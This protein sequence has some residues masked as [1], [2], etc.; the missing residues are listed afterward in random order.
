MG[1][2]RKSDGASGGLLLILALAVLVVS[3]A[4]FVLIPVAVFVWW[5]TSELMSIA[6]GGPARISDVTATPAERA[7]GVRLAAEAAT[8][9]AARDRL[10]QDGMRNQ[11]RTRSDGLFDE[12][13]SRARSLNVGIVSHASNCVRAEQALATH[14]HAID[15]RVGRWVRRRSMRTGSRVGV[16]TFLA[17]AGSL[18][19]IR[20]AFAMQVGSLSFLADKTDA[21]TSTLLGCA[22]VAGTC[23]WVANGIAYRV[24]RRSLTP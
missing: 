24:R 5:L 21:S 6:R 16:A 23:A 15:L 7:E 12:R 9:R 1:R 8:Q 13:S 19:L 22:A 4:F 3:V 2:R 10:V 18:L 11:L 20:P 17:V 14:E